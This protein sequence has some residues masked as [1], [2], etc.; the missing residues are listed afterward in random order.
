MF[1]VGDMIN[2][3]FFTNLK[4][5]GEDEHHF[6]LQDKNGNTKKVF[7]SLIEKHAKLIES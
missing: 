7:K 1:K 6:I 4:I 5:V 2:Y 3:G